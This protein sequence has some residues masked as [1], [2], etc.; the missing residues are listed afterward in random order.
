M[1][2]SIYGVWLQACS[3][4]WLCYANAN[5]RKTYEIECQSALTM[6]DDEHLAAGWGQHDSRIQGFLTILRLSVRQPP[7]SS[8]KSVGA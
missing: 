3:N 2:I 4:W 5:I 1:I 8:Y 7:R 6:I